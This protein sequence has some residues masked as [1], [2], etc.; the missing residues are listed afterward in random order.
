[1]IEGFTKGLKP[2]L[3]KHMA[4]LVSICYLVNPLQQQISMVLH[5]ISHDLEFPHYVMSHETNLNTNSEIHLKH[6]H[7]V[8]TSDHEHNL[9]DFIDTLFQG[10]DESNPSNDSLFTEI[11]WDKHISSYGLKLPGNFKIIMANNF[12]PHK[13]LKQHEQY[14]RLGRPPQNFIG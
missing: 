14:E 8:V 6:S 10:L 12:C 13:Q 5:E 1:M 4:L 7:H 9:I 3:I 11:K 2:K